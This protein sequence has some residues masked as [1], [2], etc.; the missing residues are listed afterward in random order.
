MKIE[1]DTG[2]ETPRHLTELGQFLLALAGPAEPVVASGV[3]TTEGKRY[4]AAEVAAGALSCTVTSGPAEKTPINMPQGFGLPFAGLPGWNAP[5]AAVAPPPPPVWPEGVSISAVA[6]AG[7]APPPPP[8]DTLVTD[9]AHLASDGAPTDGAP[10]DGAVELD[11]EG[12]PW[13][14]AIHSSSR[15]KIAD[16]T[17]RK[18]RTPTTPV[19]APPPPV[20]ATAPPPPAAYPATPAALSLLLTAAVSAGRINMAQVAA[21]CAAAGVPTG[22][23]GIAQ[24]VGAIPAICDALGLIP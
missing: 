22:L 13:D 4:S 23:P 8:V 21:A 10:T 1:I 16:G 12:R 7:I 3:I 15:A 2:A 9:A 6:E 19:A 20:A 18:R 24:N 14:E 11:S 17:W 5:P